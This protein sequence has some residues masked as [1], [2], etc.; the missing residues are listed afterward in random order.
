MRKEIPQELYALIVKS[1]QVCLVALMLVL[2]C[3][4]IA[5]TLKWYIVFVLHVLL[6][7]YAVHA[8][9]VGKAEAEEIKDNIVILDKDTIFINERMP[10]NRNMFSFVQ[11][12]E[13]E[14]Q[15][16]APSATYTSV[17]IGGVTTGS[18]NVKDGHFTASAGAKT[19]K[20][21]LQFHRLDERVTTE[22]PIFVKYIKL[23]DSDAEI[24]KDTPV[25]RYYLSGQN[26]NVLVLEH[27]TDGKGTSAASQYYQRTGDLH[28]ATNLMKD[29]YTDSLLGQ[30]ELE[31]IVNFLC[32]N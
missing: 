16:H 1:P 17:T 5:L 27:K 11:H 26:K 15:Y 4:V 29:D 23:S 10:E 28:G 18:V 3:M 32:G 22:K 20:Y 2:V 13:T 8:Y 7:A 9:R 31:R 21:Y 6:V 12:R 24:A 19:D 14:Y 30:K 25:I